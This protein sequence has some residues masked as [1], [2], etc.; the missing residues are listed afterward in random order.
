MDKLFTL[1]RYLAKNQNGD[2]E[3]SYTSAYHALESFLDIVNEIE[4][5]SEQ[6]H[7][8]GGLSWEEADRITEQLTDGFKTALC[9]INGD[10]VKAIHDFTTSHIELKEYDLLLTLIGQ[11]KEAAKACEEDELVD[12]D[13]FPF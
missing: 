1:Y 12:L 7:D 13:D 9:S 2:P 11:S 5:W 4:Y 10:A 8:L 3:N 6:V